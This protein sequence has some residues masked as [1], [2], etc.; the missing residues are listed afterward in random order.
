MQTFVGDV[1]RLKERS[2]TLLISSL[3]QNIGGYV[4]G[5]WRTSATNPPLRIHNPATGD[6]LAEVPSLGAH[7]TM[8]AANCG[9]AAMRRPP[10]LEQRRDWLFTLARELAANRNELGRIITLEQGKPL[11]EGIAEVDYAASYFAYYSEQLLA[12]EPRAHSGRERNCE[13]T[14]LLR[15]A[16]VVGVIT[17][18]NFPLAMLT[19]KLG[20]A[21]G[22][23]C[24]VVA[25]PS[26]L[27]PLSA[28]ALWSLIDRMD[29]PPGFLNLVVGD[30]VPIGKVLC[31]F[32]AIRVLSFTGSTETGRLLIH[33]SA[34]YVK[35]LALELGG[36]A[37]FVVFDD[38]DIRS[39]V[40]E[41]VANKFRAGGQTCVC[42]NRVYV[43]RHIAGAFVDALAERV[44]RLRVGDGMRP[45]TD[46]GP[47]INRSAFEK[48]DRHVRDAVSK[49]AKRIV[50]EEVARPME[51]WGCFYPA[52]VLTGIT[53]DMEVCQEE[54]FGPVIS[55]SEFSD[56]DTVVDDC[57]SSVYGL[58]AYAFT[59][60][61]ARGKRFISRLDFGHIGLNTGTGPSPHAPFGGMKQSGFGREG[62]PEG[63]LEFCETQTIAA[64]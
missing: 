50:G 8:D 59:R 16:G 46:I 3:L 6:E 31:Q 17:P 4:N 37:P 20:A 13:W 34:P 14:V 30:P 41:L 64:T 36:N 27:T 54:T 12:L 57:N 45:D 60:D 32:P 43:Q 21:I 56:E 5:R 38:A 23:G 61:S 33:E 39:A 62:G 19:K 55:V 51:N 25:K 29:I 53:P 58:A 47:L 10:T 2:S 48:V 18:W 11:A 40:D 63:L 52:T 28:I 42:A 1:S 35:R 22:A 24:A 7:D 49:G 15:P 44:S 26:E 9:M